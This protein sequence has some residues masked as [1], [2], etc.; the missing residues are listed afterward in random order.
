VEKV[1]ALSLAEANMSAAEEQSLLSLTERTLRQ[2]AT[3]AE[4]AVVCLFTYLESERLLQCRRFIRHVNVE[5]SARIPGKLISRPQCEH[6]HSAC[7]R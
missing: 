7:S 1:A 6:I 3:P 5:P 4:I 2:R